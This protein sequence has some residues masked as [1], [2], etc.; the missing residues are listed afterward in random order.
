MS[1]DSYLLYKLACNQ[2]GDVTHVFTMFNFIKFHS[3]RYTQLSA[4]LADEYDELRQTGSSFLLLDM[5]FRC[6]SMHSEFPETDPILSLQPLRLVQRKHAYVTPMLH[7][8]LC[9][10]RPR[11]ST[12]NWDDCK[13][14]MKHL[15]RQLFEC[16]LIWNRDRHQGLLPHEPFRIVP[17][18]SQWTRNLEF[19][20]GIQHPGAY[21][22]YAEH[23]MPNFPFYVLV[24]T[25]AETATETTTEDHQIPVEMRLQAE[26]D[27]LLGL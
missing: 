8:L 15:F 17:D 16:T 12:Y 13:S 10:I 4:S 27:R 25:V 9:T 1:R 20:C 22:F 26:Y 14:F 21:L 3:V 6:I 19:L 23:Y 24:K 11:I 5:I 2:R 7:K 18:A